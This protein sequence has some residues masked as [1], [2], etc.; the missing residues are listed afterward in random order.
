MVYSSLMGIITISITVAAGR[1]TFQ[2][3]DI[4]MS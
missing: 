1:K 4:N 3:N 2:H